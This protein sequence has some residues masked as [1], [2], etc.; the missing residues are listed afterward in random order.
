MSPFT[1]E[2]NTTTDSAIANPETTKQPEKGMVTEIFQFAL[3]AILIVLPIRFFIAQPFIV[4]GAS[5]ENTFHTNEYLIIDRISYQLDEPQRGDV[6]VFR[7]PRNPS[8]F[9]IKRL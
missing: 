3:L 6:V 7:Y 9:F 4:S 5:M 8:Q 1:P 2:E